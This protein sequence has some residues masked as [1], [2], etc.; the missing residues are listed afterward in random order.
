L[1]F[2]EVSRNSSFKSIL[3]V[4]AFYP[5]KQKS[6]IPKKKKFKPLSISNQKSFVIDPIFS[7]GFALV[8]TKYITTFFTPA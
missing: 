6:F 3:K 7:E 1:K 4:S 8:K 2:C 5:E